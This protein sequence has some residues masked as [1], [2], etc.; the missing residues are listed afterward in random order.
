MFE[1]FMSTNARDFSQ[2][3][4]GTYGFYSRDGRKTLVQLVQVDMDRGVVTFYDHNKAEYRLN[5]DS[6]ENVGFE[7]IPPKCE[8]HNTSKGAMLVRRVPARQYSR[9][10][11]DNNTSISDASLR[12]QSVD[13]ANL[14]AI[15]ESKV[16]AKKAAEEGRSF[17][18]GPQ[19]C[20]NPAMGAVMLFNQQI[21]EL[22][23]KESGMFT[24]RLF[25][26]ELFGVEIVDAFR[27]SDI[28]VR[29][30]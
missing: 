20:V 6:T 14:L 21:G 18:V 22:L 15:F 29:I 27:R 24:I 16:S 7:F 26:S 1:K 8:W 2:R 23:P 30:K 19:F 12:P 3:Y 17:A 4:Q 9:G 25:D 10:I 28:P 11:C 5:K 13:F